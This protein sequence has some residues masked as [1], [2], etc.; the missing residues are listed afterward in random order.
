LTAP[1]YQG[2][3]DSE[4]VTICTVNSSALSPVFDSLLQDR[5]FAEHVFLRVGLPPRLL[6]IGDCEVPQVAIWRLAAYLTQCSNNPH[7]TWDCVS[8]YQKQIV[9]S[10]WLESS[11]LKAVIDYITILDRTNPD[12]GFGWYTTEEDLWLVR[13][14][15]GA[16]NENEW[17]AELYSIAV[18]VKFVQRLLSTDCLPSRIY[19]RSDVPLQSMP[20]QWHDSEIKTCQPHTAVAIPLELL[21]PEGDTDNEALSVVE[22]SAITLKPLTTQQDQARNI[23]RT[24][25]RAGKSD[26]S[27]PAIALGMSVR[28]FQRKLKALGL[29]YKALV[30][31]SRLERARELLVAQDLTISDIAFELGYKHPGDFTR[32]FT[33]NNRMTPRDY[34]NEARSSG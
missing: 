2:E 24:F 23:V 4:V 6:G 19:L 13:R 15:R 22:A 34:R 25:V 18:Y 31:Q 16:P 14:P 32:A 7:F 10:H 1:A 12:V 28:S 5:D 17:P 29:N 21:P 27:S 26:I 8:G 30:S 11:P 20:P 9:S 3:D 33:L